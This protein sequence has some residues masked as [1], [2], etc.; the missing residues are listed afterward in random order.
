[1]SRANIVAKSGGA[2]WEELFWT[3]FRLSRTPIALHN[4]RRI[5]IEPNDAMCELLGGPREEIAGR[6]IDD[7]LPAD[8]R[9]GSVSDWRALWE[10][11]HYMGERFIVRLDGTRLWTQ[12]AGRICEVEGTRFALIVLLETE[13]RDK[14]SPRQLD[15]ALTPRE[16]EVLQLVALGYSSREIAEKLVIS[17]STVR[18]HV[19]NAMAKTGARTRAQL[20]AMALADRHIALDKTA[21]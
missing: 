4:R 12:F 6:S 1:M 14:S 15:G 5:L 3:V 17:N 16:R 19:R 21:A 7:F 2:G 20:V 8:E 10:V 11:G 18:T 9:G 13:F